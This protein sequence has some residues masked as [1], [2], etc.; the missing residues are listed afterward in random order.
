MRRVEV[1]PVDPSLTPLE[2]WNEIRLMG[3]RTTYTGIETWAVIE[4]DPADNDPSPLHRHCW[5]RDG[6][7]P[8]SGTCCICDG[9]SCTSR[10]CLS[11]HHTT[12]I[13][14]NNGTD[15]CDDCWSDAQADSDLQR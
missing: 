9:R 7:D 11:R 1:I 2:A 4:I 15:H 14:T 12:P 6:S 3:C 8:E 13:A 5:H 10:V